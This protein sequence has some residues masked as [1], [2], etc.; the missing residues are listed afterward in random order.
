MHIWI[1][2][3]RFGNAIKKANDQLGH[4]ITRRCLAAKDHRARCHAFGEAMLD[5]QILGD[6][7]Q[8]I[9]VLALVLVNTLHLHIKQGGGIHRKTIVAMDVVT[10]L[11][12]YRQLGGLP[13]L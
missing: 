3:D 12:L 8:G 11:T 13:L 4:V 5:A 2:I 9:E 10:E 6:H 1:G 7:L